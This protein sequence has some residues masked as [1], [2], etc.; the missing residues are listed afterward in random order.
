M[1]R[2]KNKIRYL[3]LNSKECFYSYLAA[4]T[5]TFIKQLPVVFF[6]YTCIALCNI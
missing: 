6:S 2:K 3:D 1:K 5:D 4:D